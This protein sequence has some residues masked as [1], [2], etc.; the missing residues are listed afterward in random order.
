MFTIT[1]K[2]DQHVCT[3]YTTPQEFT[4]AIEFGIMFDPHVADVSL[5]YSPQGLIASTG[6]DHSSVRSCS[7]CI[8]VG[9][10]TGIASQGNVNVRPPDHPEHE[11]ARSFRN[12]YQLRKSYQHAK[13]L[14]GQ[15]RLPFTWDDEPVN[16]DVDRGASNG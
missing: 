1:I 6:L 8:G 2:C 14:S 9:V 7:D 3:D 12:V 15:F 5:S 13:E 11:L 10:G 4:W 16:A